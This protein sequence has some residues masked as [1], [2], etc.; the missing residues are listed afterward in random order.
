MT[1]DHDK[2]AAE[3][4]EEAKKEVPTMSCEEYEKMLSDGTDH[5]LLD[6]REPAEYEE[7][8]LKGAINIPRG[9]LEFKISEQVS[10]KN[11]PIIIC[12]K[13]GGRAALSGEALE[14]MGYEKVYYLEGGYEECKN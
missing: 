7:G 9:V 12:C 5:V 2:T 3:M 11:M 10:D 8:H 14:E 1:E 6:V 13:T 4:V